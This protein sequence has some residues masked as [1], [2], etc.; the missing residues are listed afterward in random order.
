MSD[1]NI[2]INTPE[3]GPY[4]HLQPFRFWCQKVLPLVY[5]ESL[6]YYELLCK[7]VD[8]LNK[9][10][11]DVDQMIT[12]IGEFKAADTEFK[13][14]VR[15]AYIAFS[16][17]VS[18]AV[19]GL[20][21]FVNNYFNNLDVQQEINNKLDAMAAAGYFDNLF[22]TLFTDDI[23]STTENYV[24]AWVAE[25][26]LQET[27]YVLD[28]SLTIENAAADAKA[29]GDAIKFS[30]LRLTAD[31]EFN[32]T[33][34]ENST[35]ST[36]GT[37]Y[38]SSGNE[39]A[40]AFIPANTR[41]FFYYVD[42]NGNDIQV[43]SR[44]GLYTT[45]PHNGSTTADYGNGY[46]YAD[47]DRDTWVAFT[48][49][50]YADFKLYYARYDSLGGQFKQLE[51][52]FY[53]ESEEID[54]TMMP[55]TALNTSNGTYFTAA[56]WTAGWAV[57]PKGTEITFLADDIVTNCRYT[58]FYP[59]LDNVHVISFGV[60]YGVKIPE[61]HDYTLMI[62]APG[63]ISQFTFDVKK[64][65]LY[66]TASSYWK[67]KKIVWFGTSIPAG[68]VLAGDE[69][70]TGAYPERIGKK[71]G[72]IVYNE[73]VG[74]SRVRAGSYHAI[75]ANDPLGWAGMSPIG[76]LLSLSVSSSEKQ[77]FIDD[78][79]DKWKYIVSDPDHT[80]DN[81]T[82]D[83]ITAYK[84][85]SW[86]IK[87]NKYLT[88]GAVG[89]CDLYV[90]DH[91]FNE[92]VA[93]YQFDDMSDLPPADDPTNRSYFLGALSFLFKKI[94]D[95]NPKAK[96]LII[97]H[98]M[99]QP[100]Q[101]TTGAY[102]IKNGI[103]KCCAGQLKAAELWGVPIIKTWEYMRISNNIITVNGVDMPVLFAYYPDGIHPA[104]DST[105][106]ALEYYANTLTPLLNE[107]R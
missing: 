10:M 96:I 31:G 41:L 99:N 26:L 8:Y 67:D 79:D 95:D 72:A 23:L 88:G 32:L 77:S 94:L 46:Y 80:M 90:F 73:A 13:T 9:T 50:S 58:L 1:N 6:S 7:V 16:R 14:E 51:S 63:S 105:G 106:Y 84:N 60:G 49:P 18:Q 29:T 42:A 62:S 15:D 75:T 85:S 34:L 36:T 102:L 71:T 30:E 47:I 11:E 12:D 92:A 22:S 48:R 65:G 55:D 61:D 89:P 69:N 59:A 37:I 68:V 93:T 39:V 27:G 53:G 4:T 2:N 3:I 91:G 5:D 38:A 87:L 104:S 44:Y 83:L 56:G 98:Y 20:E 86:D 24:S 25:N 54:C 101:G 35:M 21:T 33:V 66:N 45:E 82:P 17:E 107:I 28:K 100:T 57:V 40:Y 52:D 97:G 78:W 103:D 74:S 19:E 76:I 43:R 81:L 64:N 70:G